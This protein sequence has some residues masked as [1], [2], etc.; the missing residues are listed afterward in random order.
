MHPLLV[1]LRTDRRVQV[2]LGSAAG[3]LALVVA[4]ALA[5]HPMVRAALNSRAASLH[6]AFELDELR[7]GWF[8]VLL[9]GVRAQPEGVPCKIALTEVRVPLSFVF[10]PEAIEAH[11]G[12]V[13]LLGSGAEVEDAIDAWRARLP[14]PSKGA[15]RSKTPVTLDGLAVEWR[16]KEGEHPLLE[17]TGAS[18][19]RDTKPLHVAFESGL[20]R[21]GAMQMTVSGFDADVATGN[22]FE[23]L[24]ASTVDVAWTK[25]AHARAAAAGPTNEPTPPAL[26]LYVGRKGGATTSSSAPAVAVAPIPW[27]LPKLRLLRVAIA[28]LARLARERSA[29]GA[30]IDVDSLRFALVDGDRRLAIGHGPLSLTRESDVV[31]L[32][33]TTG[34]SADGTSVSVSAALP[35]TAG[36]AS[37][38]LAGGPVSLG[39]LGVDEGAAGLVEVDRTTI[40][41]R[42]KIALGPGENDPLTFDVDFSARALA[43][44][45]PKVADDV[46]RGLDAAMIARGVLDD[47]GTLRLDDGELALGALRV[48]LRGSVA[49]T[50]DHLAASLV[51][52]LP[53][54]K[55]Q[56]ILGSIPSALIPTLAGA[57]AEGDLGARIRLVFDSLKLDD[58]VLDA[59]VDD[60]CAMTAVPEP[61]AKEHF[62]EPFEHAIYD[63]DGSLDMETTGPTTENWTDLEHI[64][65]FMQVAV[66]TTE[67][68]AFYRHKGFNRA[69]IRNA[70][71]ANLK[72]GRFLRGASTITM[73]LAKNLFLSREKTL[74]RKLEELILADYLEQTFT[75]KE[76]ME[77]YLN[78]IEYGPNVY[79]ITQAAF[80]YFGRKPDELNLAESL[81]LSSILPSPVRYHK[82][83][84]KPQ[85]SEGWSKHLRDL[86]GIAGKLGTISADELARGLTEQV[87]FHDPKDPLPPPRPPVTGTH[88]QLERDAADGEWKEMP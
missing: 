65:P 19:T 80:H 47:S 13:K 70:L 24:H 45:E 83:A 66:L 33:F 86:M 53:K 12:T 8:K 67:D 62:S 6:L 32:T 11:G 17:I 87:V 52:E 35:L 54:T 21:H 73:Q 72:A 28:R 78:V 41:G 42:S 77:L 61:L 64:S 48:A 2:I 50:E 44:S 68:G 63:P 51:F 14:P 4:L 43:I 34:S 79:G 39:A 25:E 85:L 36:D 60:R 75:K 71:V 1:R 56:A 37:V 16:E 88:F 58:L 23:R 20:V 82:L 57:E 74:A 46:V 18:V 40:E 69:A 81:F 7:L 3:V 76:I 10:R 84:E 5:V 30:R 31:H 22:V 38:S 15:D 29:E 59:L 27:T 55:C 26:P 9:R 49:S